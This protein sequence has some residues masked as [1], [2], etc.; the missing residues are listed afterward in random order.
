MSDLPRQKIP[1]KEKT[2]AWRKNV[3]D[4]YEKMSYT[5]ATGNRTFNI[6]KL[7]NYDLF[8]GRFNR[9]D[10]EYVTNPLGLQDHEFPASL[11]HYD[12]IS[13]ALMLL[14]GEETKRPDNFRVV[15]GD[16][17]VTNKKQQKKKELIM[18]FLQHELVAEVDPSQ[19]PKDPKTGQ[20][21]PPQ[22][23]EEIEKY[24]KY[25]YS[26]LIETTANRIL[27]YLRRSLNTKR[28]FSRGWKDALIAGEEIYWAGILNGEPVLRRANP[29]DISVILDGDSDAIDDAIAVVEVR[30]LSVPT[31]LDELGDQLE[32][33]QVEDLEI[34]ATTSN[35]TNINNLNAPLVLP[36]ADGTDPGTGSFYNNYTGINGRQYPGVIRVLRVE[37]MGMKKVG[38][39]KFKDEQTGEDREI[40][41]DETFKLSPEGRANGETVE[42]FWINEAWEGVKIGHDI[43]VSMRPKPNQR[44]RL[45]NPYFSSLGY[46]GL[47]YNAT[48]S[49]SV[50]LIDRLKPYQYLY[51]I[52]MYRMELA[53][54]S[55]MGK[56]MLMDVAQIPRS[57]G[58]DIDK[59]MYYLKAMKIGFINSHE[60]GKR[61][62]RTGQVSNFNQFQSIDLTLA[63]TIQLYINT[64]DFIRN[65]VAFLSGISPAR[66]AEV[67]KESAVGTTQASIQQ[68]AYVTEYWFEGHNECRRRAYTALIEC[69]KIAWRDGKKVQY[70]L[71]DLGIEMLEVDGPEF[72]NTE[73]DVFVSNTTKD[74]QNY[75][76][77][78]SLFQSALQTDKATLSDIA[79]VMTMDSMSDISRMLQTN[80]A[81]KAQ[82]DQANQEAQ[83]AQVK[84][85]ADQKVEM[86]KE[87]M[88]L[89][90]EEMDRKDDNLERDRQARIREAEI[91]A[92]GM[93]KD[94][95][96][97]IEQA[98]LGIDAS[99]A[100][101]EALHKAHERDL[102]EK[103]LALEEKKIDAENKRTE[104]ENVN[105][106]RELE[107]KNK[108]V[109][110]QAKTP[111]K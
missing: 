100:E 68:S 15:A 4:Y 97:V 80:E 60:E 103:K 51:N 90:R 43:Y 33:K 39:Y 93:A 6:R 63:S 10:L 58:I 98:K 65:Q 20:P 109:E 12:I 3:V 82:Q 1:S 85:A 94:A 75:D 40:M 32:P 101:Q 102:N 9:R 92:L 110:K 34:M 59:W 45:D 61:G 81:H 5:S 95:V 35:F 13:P 67:G 79:R 70:V 57:E 42:W 54:A 7:I 106:K 69:A 56:I 50:S 47:I 29:P 71:D 74:Q 55:D 99:K 17:H 66:L 41:V 23:P 84:Q 48:N 49:L 36:A 73:F 91:K 18:Q 44:R 16:P 14:I 2:E 19:L 89:K 31:I 108:Q 21:I 46:T 24:M 11:Q 96:D 107:I 64:L 53:F 52:I 105:K 27:S 22:T 83:Q 86:F 25:E 88:D 37:W 30:L 111:K 104:M 77:L 62:I 38:T 78:K 76:T 72:E 26:E 8:N 28:I 87:E